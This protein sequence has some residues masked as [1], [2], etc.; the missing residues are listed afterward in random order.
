MTASSYAEDPTLR[1]EDMPTLG[2]LVDL[3][4]LTIDRH[5]IGATALRKLVAALPDLRVL[6]ARGYRF[7]KLAFGDG[8]PLP[9]SISAAT[10][11]ARSERER[12]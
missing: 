3:E 4:R 11:S 12:S 8:A 9:S 5:R 1:A 10:R 7:E 6:S 2:R